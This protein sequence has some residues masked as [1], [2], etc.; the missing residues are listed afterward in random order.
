MHAT[1]PTTPAAF[2]SPG[3]RQRTERESSLG[4]AHRGGSRAP[5]SQIRMIPPS[6]PRAAARGSV[7]NRQSTCPKR[8]RSR[9]SREPGG[10]R[11]SLRRRVAPRLTQ[12]VRAPQFLP[13]FQRPLSIR[14]E[15]LREA[16]IVR[17][18]R[19]E[20]RRS[21]TNPRPCTDFVVAIE[22]VHDV[23]SHRN[24]LKTLECETV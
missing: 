21:N 9:E 10:G 24:G 11:P 5:P 15:F 7:S 20:L 19:P 6:R 23:E 1:P 14:L 8:S 2:G 18:S 16:N 13:A 3:S 4:R 12:A 22:Q 17:A